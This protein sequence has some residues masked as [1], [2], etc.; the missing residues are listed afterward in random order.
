MFTSKLLSK[1]YKHIATNQRTLQYSL[2]LFSGATGETSEQVKADFPE[3][4]E[5]EKLKYRESW[6]IKYDDECIKFEKE[7]EQIAKDKDDKQIQALHDELDENSRNKVDFLVEKVLTLNLFEMRY[8]AEAMKTRVQKTTGLSPMK[9]NMDWP[10]VKQ[11]ADGSWPP[12]N[13]NWFKQQDLMSQVGPFM[14]SMG[15]TGGAPGGGQQADAG[16]EEVQEEAKPEKTS[17]DIELSSF[18]AKGKI[19][20]IKEI[21]S[22]LGLG[23]KDAKEMVEGA[24]AWIKKDIKKEEAEE[25]VAKLESLGATLKVV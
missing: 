16:A 14:S 8:F 17:V 1:S 7:W 21:R 24:P 18:D 23:L 2:R 25:I 20:I 5:D 19:K 12:L 22:L 4:T 3:P 15:M 13:P 10:S 9:L 11:D 6:G